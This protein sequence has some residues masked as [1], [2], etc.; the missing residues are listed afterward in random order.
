MILTSLLFV[1]CGKKPE[2]KPQPTPSEEKRICSFS[3]SNLDS[4]FSL[5]AVS[6]TVRYGINAASLNLEKYKAV[7]T[8]SYNSGKAVLQSVE[9]LANDDYSFT[10]SDGNYSYK[11]ETVLS[12]ENSFFDKT[13]G[14]FFLSLCL[15]SKTDNTLEVPI[16]VYGKGW[17]LVNAERGEVVYADGCVD[18]IADNAELYFAPPAYTESN[19]RTDRPLLLDEIYKQT[20]VWVEPISQD[21]KLKDV[22]RGTY[23]VKGEYVENT[24][25]S[26]FHFDSYRATWLA[27]K[28]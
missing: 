1:G 9:N 12:L 3:I 22:L 8:I 15:F 6:V 10:V 20:T 11:K 21:Q 13:D 2:E 19:I 26:R 16:A 18:R 7:F 25:G 23:A 4:P 28:V 27:Y 24:R 17:A 14:E 5:D